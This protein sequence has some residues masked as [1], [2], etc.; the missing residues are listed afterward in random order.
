MSN[1]VGDLENGN[2]Y[3]LKRADGNQREMDMKVGTKYPV[4]FAKIDNQKTLTGRQINEKVNDL[5]AIKFGRVE[6]VDYGKGTDAAKGRDVYFTVTGQNNSGVNADYSRSKYGRIYK[7][8]LDAADPTKGTLEVLLDGDDRNGVAKT[9]Q[10][11]DNITVTENYA[12]IQEDPNGYGDEKHDAYLYQ[13]NLKTGELKPVFI[14]D[15]RRNEADAAKYNVGGT[16]SVGSWEISGMIDV[17]DII[18]VPNTFT[19]GLQSHT[20]TGDKYKGVDGGTKRLN[21]N[22]ASQLIVIKG[23]AR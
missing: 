7:I 17:S 13:Y 18:G 16:S 20:W 21:E 23:L 2:L 6:D 3:M 11:P 5:K 22:Q 15:H 9:F 14:I 19:V 12:Y 1:T 4:E 8:T 10:D